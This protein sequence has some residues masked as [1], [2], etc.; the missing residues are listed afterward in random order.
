MPQIA[1]NRVPFPQGFRDCSACHRTFPGAI[2]S[3]P[4]VIW[5]LPNKELGLFQTPFA[6]EGTVEA[7]L[8]A[9]CGMNCAICSAF[10]AREYDLKKQ[11]INGRNRLLP[12]HMSAQ[13]SSGSESVSESGSVFD[14]SNFDPDFDTDSDPDGL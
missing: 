9:P 14:I 5:P 10:L 1:G 11:G 4:I 8:V 6:M 2:V 12:V 7:A 3:C 13:K